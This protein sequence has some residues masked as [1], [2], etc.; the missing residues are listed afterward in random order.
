[1]TPR[2][3]HKRLSQLTVMRATQ[4]YCIKSYDNGL[5]RGLS[6][7]PRKW[8]CALAQLAPGFGEDHHWG[9]RRR[10]CCFLE[11]HD[12][13]G[14]KASRLLSFGTGV[15]LS[16]VAWDLSISASF[17]TLQDLLGRPVRTRCGLRSSVFVEILHFV[18]LRPAWGRSSGLA[19][20]ALSGYRPAPGWAPMFFW[21]FVDTVLYFVHAPLSTRRC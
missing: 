20:E 6:F 4:G 11:I 18:K 19:S 14:S 21:D 3:T 2:I 9:M 12:T 8:M 1:M 16:R 13:R 5:W 15:L 17:H 10:R 7:C